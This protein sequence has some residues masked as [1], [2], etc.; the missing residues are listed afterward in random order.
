MFVGGPT[1]YKPL[2][3]KIAYELSLP[4]NIDVNPMTAVAEGASIFAESIDWSS[5]NHNRKSANE[6]IKTNIELSFKYTARTSND[7]AKIMCVLEKELNG[8]TIQFTSLDTG[9]SSGNAALKANLMVTL[10]L[11][12]NGENNFTVKVFDEFGHEQPIGTDKITI[13]KTLATIGAIPAS[14]S[15]G[16]EVVDKL[17]GVPTLEFLVT[18]GDS[19]PKKG[20][21]TFKAGQTLKAGTNDSINI[22]L[23]EGNIQSPITDNRFVGVLKI[24]GMDID[25][26]VVPTGADIECEFEMSDSGTIH[27][28]ASIPCI[29]ASFGNHNFYSRQEGQIDLTDID[30]IAEQ[31][32]Q[33]LE[34]IDSMSEKVD[35]PQLEN[36]RKKAELA[37]NIDSQ[38]ECDAEDVQKANNELLDAKKLINK[39]RQ[40]NLKVIR[41]MELDSC[42][43]FFNEVVRQYAKPAE[44]QSFD[45]LTR[46]AQRSIERNDPDFD[47]I[48]DIMKAKNTIILIR[49]DWFIVDWYQR[50]VS[51]STNYMD[52]GRFNELKRMGDTALANDD[53]DQLRQILFELLS[54]QIHSDS[55]EGMFDI[56]NIIKG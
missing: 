22:K 35:D 50:A 37:A 55:G 49:Q 17:G 3:D 1:N 24:T 34:R 32:R 25:S 39:T 19:L 23:W 45:N 27:L 8:Y 31:G 40:A 44:E 10:P 48:L 5:S 33:V 41:Q 51:S 11:S 2:R 4:A 6:T 46:T 18:E 38:S 12:K 20:T 28:E 26:G 43:E 52:L 36:A 56:A 53:I 47:N 15:I 42:V 13:T 9:W 14:H 21:I 30:S 29:G 16:V 7:M 54:I